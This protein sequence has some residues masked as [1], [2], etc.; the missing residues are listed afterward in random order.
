ER[1]LLSTELES[2]RF[3]GVPKAACSAAGGA[4]VPK[5]CSGKA[6]RG[7]QRKGRVFGEGR[8]AGGSNSGVETE[9]G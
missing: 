2:S 8:R 3:F 6:G 5:N 4:G 7:H 9:G 1:G